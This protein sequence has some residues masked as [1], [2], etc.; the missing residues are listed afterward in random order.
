MAEISFQNGKSDQEQWEIRAQT[1]NCKLPCKHISSNI[2]HVIEIIKSIF[3]VDGQ[4]WFESASYSKKEDEF[5]FEGEHDMEHNFSIFIKYLISKYLVG[6]G[7]ELVQEDYSQIRR[8]GRKIDGNSSEK[9]LNGMKLRF[10]IP[11]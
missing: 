9:L 1:N 7:Y 6:D 2:E 5:I 10:A 8:I 3:T 11:E 4:N